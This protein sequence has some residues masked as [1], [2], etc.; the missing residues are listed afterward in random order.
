[1][2]NTEMNQV[3]SKL[4]PNAD[5]AEMIGTDVE[6]SCATRR[7]EAGSGVASWAMLREVRVGCRLDDLEA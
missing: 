3:M 6:S 7:R 5:D 2:L 4:V 1:M